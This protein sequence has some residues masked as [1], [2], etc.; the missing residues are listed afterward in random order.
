MLKPQP[1]KP[2]ITRVN[3]RV[4]NRCPLTCKGCYNIFN[5]EVLSLDQCKKI[6]DKI[7]NSGT[8]ELIISGGD[9]LL[10]PDLVEF[11]K[12]AKNKGLKIGIDTVSYNLNLRLLY[13]LKDL[14]SYIGVPLDGAD[15]K[16]IETFRRGKKDLLD[17]LLY[18]LSIA[19]S[20]DVPIRLNTTVSKRNVDALDDIAQIV[21]KH[22]SIKTWSIYQWWPLRSGDKLADQMILEKSQ[23][24]NAAKMLKSKHS[25][26]KIYDRAIDDRARNTFFISSNGEVYTF[27]KT[28]QISTI[29]LG[30]IKTQTISEIL[31]NPALKKSS[32]KFTAIDRFNDSSSKDTAIRNME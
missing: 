6:L 29:I 9:P 13:N 28:S 15:Q 31:K 10:W 7:V 8:S 27:G 26:I 19:D 2:N 1:M 32:Q 20:F 11:C 5:S 21:K 12:Y 24:E 23:F 30:N 18:S 25:D 22:K 3:W 16:I 17:K 4:F 14:V